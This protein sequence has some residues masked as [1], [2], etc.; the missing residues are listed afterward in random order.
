MT[1]LSR[2]ARTTLVLLVATLFGWISSANE[3]Q[4][5]SF[6]RLYK[7]LERALKDNDLD[8]ALKVVRKFRAAGKSKYGSRSWQYSLATH[9]YA[10]VLMRR[11][12]TAEAIPLLKEAQRICDTLKGPKCTSQNRVTTMSVLAAAYST[13]GLTRKALNIRIELI[14]EL[15]KQDKKDLKSIAINYNNLAAIY[16][17][18]NNARLAAKFYEK[19]IATA[20][21]A[22]PVD[23]G[24]ISSYRTNL[25]FTYYRLG[26][27]NKA[28]K[29]IKNIIDIEKG[30]N[31]DWDRLSHALDTF[32]NMM[33]G[34]GKFHDAISLKKEAL[35]IRQKN[36]SLDYF[37]FTLVANIV[38]LLIQIDDIKGAAAILKKKILLAESR[39]GKNTA[40]MLHL[41]GMQA[42]IAEKSGSVTEAN[43]IRN[44]IVREMRR[45]YGQDSKKMAG[46]SFEF[47]MQHYKARNWLPAHERFKAAARLTV[48]RTEQD[49][50]GGLLGWQMI[51][52]VMA[53]AWK[54]IEANAPNP[55]L[56]RE[57]AFWALQ[58]LLETRAAG[59]VERA[60]T[61]IA[62]QKKNPLAAKRLRKLQELG[63]ALKQAEF[64]RS[65][66][67]LTG[68]SDVGA[69]S[70]SDE[71]VK[72]IRSEIQDLKRSADGHLFEQAEFAVGEPLSLGE[73][74]GLLQPNEAAVY[75]FFADKAFHAWV[76]TE[77]DIG[78]KRHEVNLEKIH[79]LVETLR[80]GLDLTQAAADGLPDFDRAASNAL[81]TLLFGPFEEIINKKTT[82]L[83]S[84]NGVLSSLPFQVLLRKAD[85]EAPAESGGGE[86][87]LRW[88][89]ESHA[90][91]RVPSPMAL[92]GMRRNASKSSAPKAF[93]GV[94]NPNFSLR[95]KAKK[96]RNISLTQRVASLRRVLRSDRPSLKFLSQNLVALP[97][98]EEELRQIAKLMP[99]ASSELVLG[100][101]ASEAN[102]KK[103]SRTGKLKDFRIIHFA[104]HGLVPADSDLLKEPALALSLPRR[105]T[106]NDDGLLSAS[107]IGGLDLD[108]D[109]VIL[110]ACNTAAGEKTG[111]E[112]LGGLARAF[113]FAGARSVLVSHWAVDSVTTVSLMTGTLKRLSQNSSMRPVEAFRG[114]MLSLLSHKDK[115]T[116]H[117]A[118]WAPF[119][120][121]GG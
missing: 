108:A 115:R 121:V 112:A 70:A 100:R 66:L 94:G 10:V 19:S 40:P 32:G 114:A 29:F 62:E 65:E 6:N 69:I 59:A 22:R 107:E 14:R 35:E 21:K 41:R 55:D 16:F 99:A 34:R 52:P 109:W 3:A 71:K 54:A 43:A 120:L 102:I 42:Y 83:V 11:G 67:F 56:L 24:A 63:E 84:T 46:L 116:A 68:G 93:L 7:Q 96:K 50:N 77:E 87:G 79:G 51:S 110:S 5:Q 80:K 101:A 8:R 72:R 2:L 38:E 18:Q 86:D 23:S 113:F 106:S 111:S 4:A 33:K 48:A 12:Q 98:T 1:P 39:F 119:T 9:Q 26:K 45:E 75:F 90:I 104:T 92:A 49:A 36:N 82:L 74:Q 88:L 53:T 64:D 81:Y 118:L 105:A 85:K 61:R 117:P 73:Y 17:N 57:D 78:W 76:L 103:L 91:M 47:G 20:L 95:R 30:R 37:Y 27:Y 58:Y 31:G 60:T 13:V 97:E 25:A 44:D 89:V 15:E 28:I